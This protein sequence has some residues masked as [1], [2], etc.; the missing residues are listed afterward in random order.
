MEELQE[1]AAKY[2]WVMVYFPS[3][4]LWTKEHE[5]FKKNPDVWMFTKGVL[6]SAYVSERLIL[7]SLVFRSCFY[8]TAALSSLVVDVR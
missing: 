2:R 6:N 7:W 5:I 1:W 4:S 3:K 8:S